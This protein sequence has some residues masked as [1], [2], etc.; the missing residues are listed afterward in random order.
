MDPDAFYLEIVNKTFSEYAGDQQFYSILM[1]MYFGDHLPLH[2]H[3]NMRNFWLK[4]Q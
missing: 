1:K 4:F 2:F 3:L